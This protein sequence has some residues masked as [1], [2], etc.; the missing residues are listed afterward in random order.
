MKNNYEIVERDPLV[1]D[2]LLND[3]IIFLEKGYLS[4]IKNFEIVQPNKEVID[5]EYATG[6]RL[7]HLTKFTYDE[8]ENILDK[9]S[10]IFS[11]L[12]ANN[13]TVF[14]ILD[15]DGIICN[16]YLG[17]K[18]THAISQSFS[19]L[20]SSLNGNFPGV[21]YEENMDIER[22]TNLMEN[23]LKDDVKEISTVT[24]IPTLKTDEKEKFCQGIEKVINGMEGKKFSAIFLATPIDYNSIKE[25]KRGYENL[26]T[27]LFPYVNTT[28]SLTKSEA[29]TLSKTTGETFGKTYS[30]N[31]SKTD[32]TNKSFS[33]SHSS[34]EGQTNTNLKGKMGQL[35]MGGL[36]G[37]IAGPGGALVGGQI[38]NLLL[39]SSSKNIYSSNGTS[40][41]TG[42]SHAETYGEVY[43]ENKAHQT[44][45]GEAK[46]DSTGKSIQ[47]VQK[48]KALENVIKKIERQIERI[49]KSEGNGLWNI[50]SYFLS[51]EPQNSIIAANI[52][53]GITRG[54][55][56]G[57]EKNNICIFSSF[58]NEENNNVDTIKDYLFNFTNPVLKVKIGNGDLYSSIGS[59]IN[60]DELAIKFNFPQT[61]I[62]GLD[63]VKMATFGRNQ[64]SR[65]KNEIN[66]GNLYHL[67]KAYA[68]VIKLN[69][70]NLTSHTFITGSTGAGKSN[71]VYTILEELYNKNIKFLV[72]EPTKGEYKNI[73]GGK[74]NVYVYGT[75][76]QYSELLRLNIFSFNDN[77]HILEHIDRLVEIFNACWPM[78][79]AMP[80]LL[81]EAIEKSYKMLGWD[82]KNSCNLYGEKVFPTIKHLKNALEN[83]IKNSSYSDETKGNYI[84]ALV[85]RVNSL[86][87]GIIGNIFTDDELKEEEL[88][89]KNVIIDLS[90]VPS[91]ETKSLIMGILFV[92]L[93]E[94]R[95]STHT[96]ENSKLKHV[97][98]LE[99]A[100]HL[101]KNSTNI[102]SGAEGDNLQSKSVEM[103]TNSI[104]EMRT[105]G[106]GFIIVDQSPEL[107][108]SSAIKNTNTKICLR[109]PS[110]IDREIVGKSMNL[111]DEQI[112]ELAK[113]DTGVAAVIQSDWQEASLVKFYLMDNAK[114]Y[115]HSFNKNTIKIDKSLLKELL[116]DKLPLNQRISKDKINEEK[117]NNK[118]IDEKICDIVDGK[119]I[120]EIVNSLHSS[121]IEEWNEKISLILTNMLNLNK[122]DEILKLEIISSILRNISFKDLEFHN[123]YNQWNELI[124]GDKIL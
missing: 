97:T 96:K 111:N 27:Q 104:A 47:I 53:N 94:Y 93:Q 26:Y 32:S 42:T 7:F 107:L 101:L 57:I 63:V 71:A 95:M 33:T 11:A 29:I 92:K 41:T 87:N 20:K 81:K 35:I 84:G 44:T 68:P 67:G 77:I 85:T 15:S 55:E 23:I 49:E 28:I 51:S 56:S 60:N 100:H 59:I 120:I 38:A 105:Y 45:E 70:E 18:D 122:D 106:Q 113:L 103:I 115:K 5:F 9:L 78:Y 74:A 76:I 61:S 48:N 12:Y 83:I 17:V 110:L 6:I 39:G 123:F 43:G 119:T 4:D 19:T 82:L 69:L 16:F 14:L 90:R 79:A 89:D 25:I 54:E 102:S 65:F 118:E 109:L 75:N 80:A 124:R 99:E 73:F 24:G 66:I 2:K 3:S 114:K 116:N 52:Y 21:E 58:S 37:I 46:S 22:I 86:S 31:L 10:N 121:T 88:F 112:E 91:P 1:I 40:E 72:I 13:S 30:E 62:T 64:V 98:I 36:G 34:S 117:L 108:N 50:G 8:K